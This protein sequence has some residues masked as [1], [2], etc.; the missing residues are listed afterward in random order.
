[1]R[2]PNP[3]L[4]QVYAATQNGWNAEAKSQFAQYYQ[5]RDELTLDGGC[6][7]WGLR[8]IIP[9]KLRTRVLEE[10]H[11]GHMYGGQE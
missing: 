7:M 3:T 8:V 2:I 6:I 9:P 11:V 10:L 4:S 1:M 5:R